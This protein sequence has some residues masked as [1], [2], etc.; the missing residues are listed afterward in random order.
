MKRVEIHP[1]TFMYC[2][3]SELKPS[4]EM[5]VASDEPFEHEHGFDYKKAAKDFVDIWE[6]NTCTLFQKELLKEI[7][8]RLNEQEAKTQ[9]FKEHMKPLTNN[10]EKGDMGDEKDN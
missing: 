8:H 7:Q 9:A 2:E 4:F 5:I 3:I 6:D 1:G 10:I